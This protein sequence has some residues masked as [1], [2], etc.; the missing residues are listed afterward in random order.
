M[1]TNNTSDLI[2]EYGGHISFLGELDS[3]PLDN[4]D[5]D[6]RVIAEHVGSTILF[7]A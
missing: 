5:W 7:P 1:R 2:K 4:Q 3:G 6:A